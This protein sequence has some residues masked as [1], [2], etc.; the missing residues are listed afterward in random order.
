MKIDIYIFFRRQSFKSKYWFCYESEKKSKCTLR[1][2]L[3]RLLNPPSIGYIG[4]D[5]I[6]SSC[7]TEHRSPGEKLTKSNN[8]YKWAKPVARGLL[9]CFTRAVKQYFT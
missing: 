6:N 9:V 3:N 7:T 1:V 2:A 4:I 8:E 5:M